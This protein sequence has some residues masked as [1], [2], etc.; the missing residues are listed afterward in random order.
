MI[1]KYARF[2]LMPLA[3]LA[4]VAGVW[5]GL[6]RMGWRLS[7]LG[8]PPVA[9]GPLMVV[10]LLGT[11]VS[12]ERAV[13]LGLRWPYAAPLLSGLGGLL[14]IVGIP[15]WPGPLLLLLS[16]LAL[17]A[18]FGVIMRVH[19]ASFT[20][21]MALGALALLI[22]NLLWLTGRPLFTVVLWWESFLILTIAGERLELG[23]LR[24][25]PRNVER[26]FTLLT[27]LLLA[28]CMLSIPAPDLGV[29]V[30]S[31][32]MIGLAVWLLRYDIARRTVRKPGLTRYIAVCLLSGYVWLGVGGMIGAIAGAV[33]AGT[34]YDAMLHAVFVG[35]V[36]A[37]IFGHA[38]IIVPALLG[39]HIP[40]A[41]NF[42]AP[43]VLLH[44]S[45]VARVVGNLAHSGA[46]RQWGGL[47][48][49]VALLL[50][51]VTMVWA[52]ITRGQ[53]SGI[54]GWVSGVGR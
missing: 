12:L 6:A 44:L 31:V 41:Q 53:E 54:R 14:I 51:L 2:F 50:F 52:T 48:N 39:V 5:A 25:L 27:A 42:Y 4:L 33:P 15:G 22:G 26:A 23:R 3:L 32:A 13:A 1:H 30:A 37:M 11:V 35:F 34:L 24:Q 10:G 49:A 46:L 38:P 8:P 16:S 29:R 45:L 28:G 18:V 40:F 36:F 7:E 20:L 19:A 43:F 47:L 21:V 17:V 9:H